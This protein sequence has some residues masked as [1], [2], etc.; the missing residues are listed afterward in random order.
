MEIGLYGNTHGLGKRVGDAFVLQHT[1]VDEICAV[2]IAQLAESN[3]FHS[4]WFP[5][6][7]CMPTLSG[8]QHPSGERPYQSQHNI[9]DGAVL[10]GSVAAATSHIKLGTA[11]LI[12][13]YRHPLSDARQFATIDLLSHGRL[14][15]GVGSGWL[16]EEFDALEIRYETRNERTSECIE[17][18]KKCWSSKTVSFSG[19]YYHFNDISMDPKPMQLPRP[20]ILYGGNTPFGALRAIEQCDGLFPLFFDQL[21]DP[22]LYKSLQDVIRHEAD[23][24]KRNLNKFHM[25]AA[26]WAHLE[27]GEKP[28][29]ENSPRPTLT[30]NPNQII[31]HL[32]ELAGAG[33][34]LVVC[35][36]MCPSGSVNELKDQI[37]Q[38]GEEVIPIVKTVKPNGEWKPIE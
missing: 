25:I 28:S 37:Q 9:L 11:V 26:A 14:L 24:A 33:Y 36:L 4:I 3:S 19:K 5:D 10:M 32:A 34:S 22:D 31:D 27:N 15:L 23:K 35:M 21:F 29:A 7:V 2:E 12:A 30:G 6:H 38:F 20:P 13:P 17:I 8:S 1:P 16:R 18:Y